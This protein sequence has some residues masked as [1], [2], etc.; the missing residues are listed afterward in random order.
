MVVLDPMLIATQQQANA[1]WAGVWVAIVVGTLAAAGGFAAAWASYRA[2]RIA[3]AVAND[4]KLRRHEEEIARGRVIASYLFTDVGGIQK[5]CEE[6]I[7]ALDKVQTFTDER[8][9]QLLD[10]ARSIVRE[11]DVTKIQENLEKLIWL[12][13]GHATALAAIPD[14]KRV[15]L[16]VMGVTETQFPLPTH[17]H[18]AAKRG[19]IQLEI[20]RAR[21]TEFIDE[22]MSLFATP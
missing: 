18:A 3:L 13:T 7:K 9:M 5:R 1:A 12:P 19:K 15:I 21:T 2:A 11:M 17:A 22:F 16:V 20:M 14:M 4:E 6:A 10:S 8:A